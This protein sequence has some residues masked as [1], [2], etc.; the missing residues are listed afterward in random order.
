MA[1]SVTRLNW[2]VFV[3]R[4]LITLRVCQFEALD[5]RICAETAD[6]STID[7][8]TDNKAELIILK[9]FMFFAPPMVRD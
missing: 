5:V 2:S 8:I 9:V 4:R 7:T 1:V 6:V 3:S